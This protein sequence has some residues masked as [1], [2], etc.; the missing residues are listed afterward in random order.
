MNI[1]FGGRNSRLDATLDD[2]SS[3]ASI[4]KRLGHKVCNNSSDN[5]RVAIFVDYDPKEK[6][7]IRELKELGVPLVL[8]KQ[9]PVVTAPLHSRKNPSGLFDLVITRGEPG[10]DPLFNTF[11]E[12]DTR[13]LGRSE[14]QEN[15]VAINANK[16]SAVPGEL[17]SLRRQCYAADPRIDLYGRG[18]DEGKA[19]TL[20]RVLKENL[21]A[22][23]FGVLPKAGNIKHAFHAPAN[24]MGEA[25]DKME[26]LSKHKVSLVIENCESYM[27]EKLVDA[28]L[29]GCIP[30]YVGANPKLFGIPDDLY[31]RAE[32]N[33]RSVKRGIEIAL[34]MAHSNFLT[35]VQ[36]W[37]ALPGVKDE[38]QSVQVFARILSHIE[39]KLVNSR[40]VDG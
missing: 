1:L 33:P 23:R 25:K 4:A 2:I 9:E 37:M 26:I 35:R 12:W 13:F 6:S 22:I 10:S 30:V 34:E 19:Q 38:W 8:I 17:Y 20:I 39:D 16:W 27:S 15:I 14:R 18:W 36:S 7:K 5:P 21:I 31:I 3:P 29:A 11:Q 32:A 28:L 24:Y 40:G